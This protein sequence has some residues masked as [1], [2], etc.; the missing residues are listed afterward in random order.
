MIFVLTGHAEQRR[1]ERGLSLDFIA[2]A[3]DNPDVVA[4]NPRGNGVIYTKTFDLAGLF[5]E[6]RLVVDD[7]VT[8][9]RIV[10]IFVGDRS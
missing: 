8:P 9:N 5:R 10:T 4:E 7:T 2:E 3:F 6:V 1:I